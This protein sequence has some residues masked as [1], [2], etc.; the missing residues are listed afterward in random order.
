MPRCRRC[1]QPY[2]GAFH[3]NCPGAPSGPPVR[4]VA[5]ADLEPLITLIP[6]ED[7]SQLRPVAPH[8]P[9]PPKPAARGNSPFGMPPAIGPGNETP[10]AVV[11][12]RPAVPAQLEAPRQAAP[13]VAPA[14]NDAGVRAGRRCT[15]MGRQ[16]TQQRRPVNNA[17]IA[18]MLGV[19]LV[20]F[21]FIG[22]LSCLIILA[23]L[24]FVTFRFRF[25]GWASPLFRMMVPGGQVSAWHFEVFDHDRNASYSVVIIDPLGVAPVERSRVRIRGRMRQNYFQATHVLRETDANGVP[26]LGHDGL[27]ARQIPPLWL[28]IALL[29]GGVLLNL[30]YWIR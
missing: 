5:G 17:A 8:Q 2:T 13:A 14:P 6:Q 26:V 25:F 24:V 16:Q 15:I 28:A 19:I 22:Y 23:L 4:P 18:A 1:Q 27:I 9:V 7:Q 11:D 12:V 30:P 3:V 20:L 29:A 21:A 10:H